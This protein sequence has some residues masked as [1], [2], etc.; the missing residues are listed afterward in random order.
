MG[1]ELTVTKYKVDSSLHVNAEA[2]AAQLPIFLTEGQHAYR[3]H[4]RSAILDNVV[5]ISLDCKLAVQFH[6]STRGEAFEHIWSSKTREQREDIMIKA[7]QGVELAWRSRRMR[8]GAPEITLEGMCGGR[9]EGFNKLLHH[10]YVDIKT[11]PN[12]EPE[13]PT[14]FPLLRHERQWVEWKLDRDPEAFPLSR[15]KR[16]FQET[17][18]IQKHVYLSLFVRQM[19][20]NMVRQFF[21]LS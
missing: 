7:L 18:L 21:E 12:G 15:G 5:A 14:D 9:G 17:M 11:G 13:R 6:E 10:F 19:M 8:E 16:A 1:G 20:P 2:Q 4:M 3:K